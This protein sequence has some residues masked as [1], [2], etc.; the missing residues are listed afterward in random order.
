MK[1]GL[2]YILLNVIG[3]IFIGIIAILAVLPFVLLLTGSVQSE[4]TI[5]KYG[6]SLIPR[7]FKL[8]AYKFIFKNPEQILRA[9]GVTL[10]ITGFGT[11]IGV[12]VS[13]MAAYVLSR[14]N[15]KYRNP[16]AFYLF[17]TT[18]FNGGLMPYYL[19]VT[20]YLKLNNTIVILML[21]GMLNVVYIFIIRTY[22]SSSIPDS[23][24]ESA[25]IDGAN[26]LY[27]FVKIILPLLKPAVAS[28][29]LFTALNYWNDWSTAMLFITKQELVP[30]QYMLYKMLSYAS[31]TQK[32]L[33][34]NSA[35]TAQKIPQ[36]TTK[37]ALT[38]VVTGP[39]ILAYPFAQRY[40][41]SGMTI[42]AVK[43]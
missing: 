40:L 20:N 33:S 17:F 25:K 39:I 37:L 6:Y 5:L 30:L 4:G 12:F 13:C 36:E 34:E 38:A 18:L 11:L 29:S 19:L 1:R 15:L 21:S 26:D 28:I 7:E 2:D 42:G 23:M 9:Y 31:F 8:D 16:L 41:I 35:I 3:Y 14:K 10:F 43:G 24:S 32:I 27:C 22:I